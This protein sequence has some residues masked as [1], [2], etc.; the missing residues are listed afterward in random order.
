MVSSAS[1]VIWSSDTESVARWARRAASHGRPRVEHVRNAEEEHAGAV[2]LLARLGARL[3]ATLLAT[4]GAQ[5]VDGAHSV[6]GEEV[7]QR[8]GFGRGAIEEGGDRY[9]GREAAGEGEH[10]VVSERALPVARVDLDALRPREAHHP[11]GL[12]ACPQQLA[13]LGAQIG[14]GVATVG[15]L[16]GQARRALGPAWLVREATNGDVGRAQR[17][18]V[19][20]E[21]H[22]DAHLSGDGRVGAEGQGAQHVLEA[23][24]PPGGLAVHGVPARELVA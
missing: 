1:S 24:S 23:V 14:L 2:R 22:V 6:R 8:V 18:V 11:D 17:A 5:V 15:V 19:G 9:R 16:D 21:P 4:L 3:V 10:L 7:S 12:S 20:R 13:D